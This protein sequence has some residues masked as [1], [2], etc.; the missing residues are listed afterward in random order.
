M[1]WKSLL[2][3]SAMVVGFGGAVAAHAFDG[4]QY[5]KDAKISLEQARAIALKVLPGGKITHE[6]LETEKG[7]SGLRYSFDVAINKATR[8][9]GVDAKTGAVLE[10]SAEGPN[11]D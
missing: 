1:K 6:E 7:G 4:Q 8:E 2:T 10:N 5:L 3:L 9:V 11:K